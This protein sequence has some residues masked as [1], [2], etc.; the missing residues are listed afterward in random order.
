[1][2]GIEL[3]SGIN[4][5]YWN[6][7]GRCNHKKITGNCTYTQIGISLCSRYFQQAA[8]ENP[9]RRNDTARQFALIGEMENDGRMGMTLFKNSCTTAEITHALNS[10]IWIMIHD[11]YCEPGKEINKPVEK[12]ISLKRKNKA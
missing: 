3:K 5:C 10:Q 8:S 4:D 7:E 2:N 12:K 1:M 6:T 11:E 9:N